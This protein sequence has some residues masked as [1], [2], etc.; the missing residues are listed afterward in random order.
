MA[1]AVNSAKT[2]P[3]SEV[4][5]YLTRPEYGLSFYL[6]KEIESVIP[7]TVG[8]KLLKNEGQLWVV[9]PANR[10]RFLR[11][12]SRYSTEMR[13]VG[14]IADDYLLYQKSPG[15]ADQPAPQPRPQ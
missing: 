12:A 3:Y 1:Q 9:F 5:F 15:K 2:S 10:Q 8:G 14:A 6:D 11:A 13:L 4:L 7:E